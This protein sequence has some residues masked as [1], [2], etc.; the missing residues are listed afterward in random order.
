MSLMAEPLPGRTSDIIPDQGSQG[1][2]V[3]QTPPLRTAT[4]SNAFAAN[5]EADTS[6]TE[7]LTSSSPLIVDQDSSVQVV[8]PATASNSD[9]HTSWA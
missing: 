9:V 1:G 2:G 7:A 8:P 3:L 4:T 6:V 5:F